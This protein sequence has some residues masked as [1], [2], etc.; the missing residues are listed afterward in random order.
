M[1][2]AS[3]DMIWYGWCEEWCEIMINIIFFDVTCIE[4]M[5]YATNTMMW[6]TTHCLYSL[7]A[8]KNNE[9]WYDVIYFD[10]IWCNMYGCDVKLYDCNDVIW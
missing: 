1:S 6:V 2:Y 3:C 4:M 7:V 5:W 9:M 10:M 8:M